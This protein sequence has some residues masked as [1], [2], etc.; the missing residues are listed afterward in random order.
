VGL[1]ALVTGCGMAGC[2]PAAGEPATAS[3]PSV[4]ET[5]ASAE[6]GA[7][8]LLDYGDIE[9]AIGVRFDVAAATRSKNTFTCVVQP[10]LG[11]ST[12][13]SLSVSTTTAD[14]SVMK[15]VVAP[16]GADSV[17]GLGKWG[18]QTIVKAAR[19]EGPRIEVGWLSGDGRLL[20][21]RFTTAA[22]TS[23]VAA[24]AAVP[25]VVAL[26][27]KIDVSRV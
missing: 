13:L 26:A 15:D 19:G 9:A 1:V 7:C 24:D 21:L 22:G 23:A 16:D 2:A 12:H 14:I 18:Y 3:S 8:Y 20:I 5:P 27:R 10:A 11:A 25:K 4:A 17:S 6:G